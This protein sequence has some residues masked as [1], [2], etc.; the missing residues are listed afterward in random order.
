M[1]QGQRLGAGFFS[2]ILSDFLITVIFIVA[3][4]ELRSISEDGL[5]WA[6][7]LVLD[8]PRAEG[9]R[10][11]LGGELFGLLDDGDFHDTLLQLNVGDW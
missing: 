4:F 9:G 8:D 3:S 7:V 10:R 11:L 2:D 5:T 1:I 6:L